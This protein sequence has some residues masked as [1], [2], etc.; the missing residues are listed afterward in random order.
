M[1]SELRDS[2][3][4]APLRT[5]EGQ[6]SAVARWC[7]GRGRPV[8]PHAPG[9]KTP[10]GNCRARWAPAHTHRGRDCFAA[11][12]WCHGFH[13]ATPD[14]ER[15]EQWWGAGPHPGSGPHPGVGVARG[16]AGPVVLDT[17]AHEG[18]LPQRDRV[19]P[20]VRIDDSVDLRGPA[21]GFHTTGVPTA[22]RGCTSAADDDTTLRVRIPSGG[23]HGGR[24]D[25][26]GHHRQGSTGS[27]RRAPVR[28]VDLRAHGGCSVTP[29]AVTEAGTYEPMGV[30][31]PAS[32][33]GRTERQLQQTAES[34]RPGQRRRSEAVIRGGPNA[35]VRRPLHPGGRA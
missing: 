25:R 10:A 35:G 12:R 7:A 32:L 3:C 4:C 15:I 28:Q 23:P 11:D 13:A 9:R 29:G 34:A 26:P 8:R 22:P 2:R 33:P 17:D 18:R 16:P 31:R 30:V 24:R 6:S 21:N 27:G 5:P 14:V 1:A 19:L 20:G